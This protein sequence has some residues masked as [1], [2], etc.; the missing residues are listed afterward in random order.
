MST[1]IKIIKENDLSIPVG[2]QLHYTSFFDNSKKSGE[3]ILW[4]SIGIYNWQ[5]VNRNILCI[6]EDELYPKYK[7]Y[8]INVIC[9]SN[10]KFGYEGDVYYKI[11]TNMQEC[12][13]HKLEDHGKMAAIPFKIYQDIIH[14]NTNSNYPYHQ[15]RFA[16]KEEAEQYL[17]YYNNSKQF[18]FKL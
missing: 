11:F 8:Y 4:N 18:E 5:D 1:I 9:L 13:H 10:C 3:S 16:T 2:T 7:D 14:D 15:Q 17:I 6:K 12:L